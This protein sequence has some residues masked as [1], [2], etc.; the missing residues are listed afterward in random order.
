MKID[1]D[2]EPLVREAFAASVAEE[3]ERFESA[4]EAL[5]RSDDLTS[6]SLTLAFAVDSAALFAIHQGRP[7]DEQFSSLAESFASSQSWSNVDEPTS[8]IYLTSLADMRPP[9]DELPPADLAFAAFAVGGWLLS[10]FKIGDG[11]HWYDFLDTILDTLEATPD[12]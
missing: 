1:K 6:R 2:I 10:A 12:R 11:I 3:P 5:S 8:R 9:L 4:L 7:S